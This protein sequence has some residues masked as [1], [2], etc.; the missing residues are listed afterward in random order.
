MFAAW[1]ALV[2]RHRWGVLAGCLL[3]LLAAVAS[4]VRGGTLTSGSIEGIEADRAQA[5]VEKALALPGDASF[6]LVFQ[7]AD[8][9]VS[10]PR[11]AAAV[12]AA[13][14]PL[15]SDPRVAGIVDPFELPPVIARRLVSA[16]RQRA[17]VVV[18]LNGSLLE[19]ARAYPELRARVRSGALDILATG[20]VAFLRDLDVTLEHDL[21]LAELVS[22]PLALLVLL[23]VFGSLVAAALPIAIG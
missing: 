15:R 13:L 16:D 12:K 11:Y 19:A 7:S 10:D 21:L 9:A 17:I 2:C 22:L 3:V 4:L 1:G 14:A 18:K 23:A 5:M 6:T 8:L 20:R